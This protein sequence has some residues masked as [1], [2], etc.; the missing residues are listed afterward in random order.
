[1]AEQQ[2]EAPEREL[3]QQILQ[4]KKQ[5]QLQHQI[6]LQ[7]FQQQQKHLAEQHE[8]QLRQHLKEFWER[9]KQLQ[10]L[11]QREQLEALRKKEKH[12]ESA[13]AST[14]VKHKLQAFLRQRASG[15][16]KTS[17]TDN[18]CWSEG[19]DTGSDSTTNNDFP[20]R[21]TASEPNLLKVRLKQRVMERRCSPMSKRHLPPSLKKKLLSSCLPPS[22]SPPQE[23]PKELSPPCETEEYQRHALF[24]SPSMPN[25]SLAA[26]HVL[27]PDLS[28]AAVRAA[29]TARLGMPLTGQMLP[30]TLPFYPSLPAI[31]SEHEETPL[32]TISELQEPQ[33]S[34]GVIRPLGRTQ[35]SPLP[36]GHPLLEGPPPPVPQPPQPPPEEQEQRDLE[37]RANESRS[38]RPLSRALSSP[39]VHLGAPDG[40]TLSRRRASSTPTTGLAYDSQMLKHACICGNNAIHPEHAGRLQSIWSRLLETG[41]VSRCDR[42]RPRKASTTELQMC[43]SEAHALLYGT[44]SMNRHKMDMSKLSSLP[45]TAFVR[46]PCGGIGVDTDTTWN[47]VYTAPA[48]RMA[49]GCT[50]DLAVRTWTGDIRNGFAVVRPP[51]HHA[52]PQ[53]AMGFCFFNS[54]AIAA[55]VLQR[56]HRVHKIL[57]FDWGVHHGNGTQDIFYDDPRVLVISMHRHD[58]GNFFPGTGSPGECGAGAG[59]GFNVNI[60]WSGGLNPPL[61]DADYLAAF[62]AIVMPIAREFNPDI[63]LVSAG[64]DATDGHLPPLGGYKVSA[65]CFGHMTRQ[66]M[67]LARGRVV[68]AL[69]G[70]YD[71]PSI[72]DSAEECVRVLLGDSPSPIAPSELARAPCGNAVLA[73]QK[74]I[75]V[76]S[77]HWPCLQE[78]A[79]SAGCSFNDAVRNEKD[80]KDTVNA[81]ASLSMQHNMVGSPPGFHPGCS[82]D[83]GRPSA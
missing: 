73:L 20:L 46:L 72:C 5:H 71:L 13:V 80:D 57:I 67:Q 29:C 3:E 61:A 34:R 31:E 32:D 24:S 50:V 44:S 11:R 55:R 18:S 54:V 65:A 62:R 70:G 4:I 83:A 58:D 16:S 78:A 60:A 40:P 8:Q 21:K 15:C 79:K 14:E 26:H 51:G 48:A 22:E 33:Q 12:E 30:G 17:R 77:A 52:E 28:E 25:I 69:E 10:E 35:S 56:E 81:M 7:H 39:V 23:P 63:V 36:L 9:Q 74:V 53:Q 38:I 27:S 82:P 64:F 2:R 75:S 19:M 49:V 42:L 68:L 66:L 76:Q 43:H 6:L 37:L 41:L 1:M 59:V 47:E 45:V